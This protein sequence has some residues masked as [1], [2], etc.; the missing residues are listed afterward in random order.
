MIKDEIKENGNQ[1]DDQINSEL[2][3]LFEEDSLKI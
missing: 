3:D 2:A 1:L